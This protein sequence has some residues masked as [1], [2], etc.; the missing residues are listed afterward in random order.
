MNVKRKIAVSVTS[1]YLLSLLLPTTAES[2]KP[3][4]EYLQPNPLSRQACGGR[5]PM[6]DLDFQYVANLKPNAFVKPKQIA[7]AFEATAFLSLQ[8][9]PNSKELAGNKSRPVIARNYK[10]GSITPDV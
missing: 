3:K 6:T 9:S 5:T 4:S 1:I 7:T 8:L 10:S 2:A